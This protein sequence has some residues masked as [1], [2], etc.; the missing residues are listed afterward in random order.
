MNKLQIFKL[1]TIIMTIDKNWLIL[2]NFINLEQI[3]Q[4]ARV[5]LNYF[6]IFSTPIFIDIFGC[7]LSGFAM[8]SHDRNR[9][10]FI[11]YLMPRKRDFVF[12]LRLLMKF[13]PGESTAKHKI[14]FT[15]T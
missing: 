11:A 14:F 6:S 2:G 8:F 5:L 4:Q 9:K 10:F 3:Q 15:L 13:Q 1:K 12:S 7:I